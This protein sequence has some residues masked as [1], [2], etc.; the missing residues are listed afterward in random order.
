MQE[1]A[2]YLIGKNEFRNLCKMKPE[3]E[4]SGT[5]REVFQCEIVKIQSISKKEQALEMA[6]LKI[7]ASGFLYH[8]VRCI[9]AVLKGVGRREILPIDIKE[10]LTLNP[11][12][13]RLY[14]MEDPSGLVLYNCDYDNLD[15]GKLNE[16]NSE[17]VLRSMAGLMQRNQLNNNILNSIINQYE[18]KVLGN[19]EQVFRKSET[20]KKTKKIKK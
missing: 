11:T 5:V 12:T 3:Y 1:G 18:T 4:K 16:H 19:V 10:I 20:V 7:K 15:F 8:M 2:N 6:C 9:M 14:T 17:S 13:K